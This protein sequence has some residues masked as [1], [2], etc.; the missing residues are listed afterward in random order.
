MFT[1]SQPLR[2]CEGMDPV[3]AF[4]LSRKIA[5]IFV[6]WPSSVGTSPLMA[7]PKRL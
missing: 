5:A 1:Q 2:T 4:E 3:K 7:L 6:S